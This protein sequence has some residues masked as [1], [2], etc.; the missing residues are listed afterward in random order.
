MEPALP[1]MTLRNVDFPAP[2]GPMIAAILLW[3]NDPV[4]PLRMFFPPR[5]VSPMLS[6]SNVILGRMAL[7][8]LNDLDLPL[9]EAS[10]GLS[11]FHRRSLADCVRLSFLW[12]MAISV[13]M[14]Q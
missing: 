7:K 6:N 10:S 3:W 9:F 2:D 13:T 14:S 4:T 12:L 1:M 11:S 5:N 8:A